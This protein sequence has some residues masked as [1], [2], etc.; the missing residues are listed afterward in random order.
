M[1]YRNKKK[2]DL[3][4]GK[5]IGIGGKFEEGE[6]PFDCVIREPREECGLSL[7]APDY[8]GIITFVS[9]CYPTEQ[10]HLFTANKFSG[11]IRSCNEGEL[12]WVPKKEI[13][14]L[15]LWEGDRIF[16]RLLDED[17]PFFSLKLIYRKDDLLSAVL[18]GQALD[19]NEGK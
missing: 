1:L 16:L 5:Y 7:L 15:P 2:N 4:I 12:L 17:I 18:N 8:R 10:M 3:N 9:D 14:Q 6:S 13:N 19:V 11:E